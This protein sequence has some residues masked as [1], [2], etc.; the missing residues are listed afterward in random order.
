MRI[1]AANPPLALSA[2]LTVPSNMDN[3]LTKRGNDMVAILS[4]N[5]V[6]VACAA[7][8]L[9]LQATHAREACNSFCYHAW[10]RQLREADNNLPSGIDAPAITRRQNIQAVS[11]C[12]G[13]MVKCIDAVNDSLG[14]VTFA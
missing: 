14:D 3:D 10:L 5:G 4:C 8:C 9:R 11:G 2:A 12:N 13:R 1:L 7:A 6:L